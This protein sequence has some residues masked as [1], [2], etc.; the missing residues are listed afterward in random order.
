MQ[1]QHI[2]YFLALCEERSF[3]RAAKRCGI[4]QPSLTNAIMALERELGGAL[5]QRKPL[6]ALTALGH[7]V[8]P[9]LDRIAENA[10][11]AREAAQAMADVQRSLSMPLPPAPPS[12]P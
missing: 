7:S 9:Y 8:H 3:T 6:V 1:M 12:C 2:R 11:H 4:S 10:A 5:F